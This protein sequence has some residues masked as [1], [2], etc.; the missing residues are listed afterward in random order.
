M[1][2]IQPETCFKD[3]QV[4]W[5]NMSLG[6]LGGG[7]EREV[8]SVTR[9]CQQSLG[10]YIS[11]GSAVCIL[12]GV[13]SWLA[14]RVHISMQV[15]LALVTH[16]SHFFSISQVRGTLVAL[17]GTRP[18]LHNLPCASASQADHTQAS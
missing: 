18:A 5:V 6:I 16:I 17:L 9:R 4:H 13:I 12:N 8:G 10:T 11:P 1:W 14:G 15:T 2:Q 7:G 3:W